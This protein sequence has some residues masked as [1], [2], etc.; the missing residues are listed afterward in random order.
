[1]DDATHGLRQCVSSHAGGNTTWCNMIVLNW[2]MKKFAIFEDEL[3]AHQHEDETRFSKYAYIYSFAFLL[4]VPGQNMHTGN[5][6]FNTMNEGGSKQFISDVNYCTSNRDSSSGDMLVPPPY[7]E[8]IK[9][10]NYNE[11]LFSEPM[12]ESMNMSSIELTYV[13]R[14]PTV[15]PTKRPTFVHENR[16]CELSEWSSWSA[17][18]HTCGSKGKA[19]R[20]RIIL[21][22]ASGDGAHCGTTGFET[23]DTQECNT[24]VECPVDCVVGKWGEW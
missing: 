19:R 4:A 20:W 5:D 13:A 8:G 22:P 14:T 7:H 18:D 9:L 1:M 3:T 23:E 11:D 2:D 17:C 10:S 24:D 15:A 21:E 6:V 12:I 16:D